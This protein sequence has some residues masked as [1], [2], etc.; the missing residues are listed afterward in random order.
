MKKYV[1]FLM[2]SLVLL[3]IIATG[4]AYHLATGTYQKEECP[5][6]FAVIGDRTGGHT[7]GIYGKITEEI[8]RLK[9][10]FVITIGDMIEG[11]TDDT[12]VVNSQWKEYKSLIAPFTMPVY[13]TP[14]NHDIW[15]EAS[16]KLYQNH[17]G[18]PYYS[19]DFKG[20]HFVILDNS[21]WRPGIELPEEQI[22]WLISDL[23]K[24]KK[25][26]YTFVF[27]HKPFWFETIADNKTDT[28][29]S[30][31]SNYGVDAVFTGHYHTYFSD[32]F[33]NILYTSI[34]SS[35]GSCEPGPTGL[36][37]HFVWVAAN[38]R[39]I[40]IAPIKIGGVLPWKEVTATD[41]KF[42]DRIYLSG[43]EFEKPLPVSEDITVESTEV[44]VKLKNLN[45]D[46]LLEDTISWKVPEGWSVEPESLPI[47]I[48][49]GDSS[50]IRF[51]IKN[52]GNLYPVP[53]LSVHFPYSESKTCEIKKPLPAARKTYCYQVSTQPVIDGKISEPIWHN[54]VSLLFS[55][56]GS[57]GTID[58]VYF[59][60]SYDEVNIYI[61]AYCKEL[62]MD[63]MVATVTDHDGTMYNE[64]YVGYLFQPDIEKNVVYQIYFNPL[65]TAFDQ[66]ITMNPEGGT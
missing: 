52:K 12:T 5:I 37:Y 29:H 38:K 30:L 42:I 17:I 65:G 41:L 25:A 11:Y 57:Q 44:A 27:I 13:F 61:A 31:F 32:K 4:C 45:L 47:R 33:D 40:S 14:G 9:P 50:T 8:E 16:L 19:F 48:M 2:F 23:G 10:D 59:Y 26:P 64:D 21:R 62:K 3:L 46:F 56:D 36:E 43:I 22:N 1:L 58:S 54:P 39:G 35:G 60:F 66:K 34:G 53:V 55:P 15:D 63:S 7:P 28:L 18:N 51:S 20:L 49:A 6:H 24:N